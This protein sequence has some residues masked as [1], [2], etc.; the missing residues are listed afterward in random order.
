MIGLACRNRREYRTK[1]GLNDNEVVNVGRHTHYAMT[2][3]FAITS[4]PTFGSQLCSGA[5][6]AVLLTFLPV[7]AADTYFTD[8]PGSCQIIGDPDIYGTF[9][10]EIFCSVADK[11]SGIGIRLGF[12][13]QF[14]SVVLCIVSKQLEDLKAARSGFNAFGI[15]VLVNLLRSTHHT[16]PIEWYIVFLLVVI[17]PSSATMAYAGREDIKKSYL[18]FYVQQTIFAVFMAAAT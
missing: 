11:F 1:T 9:N 16:L 5:L 8:E 15:A 2:S 17:I 14:A 6:A 13:L 4:R 7:A 10:F 12:Y 18:A 3:H